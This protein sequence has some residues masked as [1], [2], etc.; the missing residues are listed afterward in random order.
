LVVEVE[1]FGQLE[2]YLPRRQLI[3]IVEP[4][5]VSE[6]ARMLDLDLKKVGLIT[7]NG[8]QCEEHEKIP[9]DGRLCFFAHMS[10]G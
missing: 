6:M 8:I 4:I 3:N 9:P 2:L 5:T 1:L 7:I 10:G